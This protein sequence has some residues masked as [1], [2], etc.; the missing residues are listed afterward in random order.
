MTL[1]IQFWGAA[2]TVTGSRHLLTSNGKRVLVDAGLFQGDR[3][4]RERNWE[5]FPIPLETLDAIVLTHAHVDHIGYLP[6]L[7]A[8]GF[9][10]V[11][12]ATSATVDLAGLVLRDSAHLQEE[13]AE[14][15]N[16]KGATKHR[17]ALPLYNAQDAENALRLLQAHP[18]GSSFTP[19][20]GIDVTFERAGHIL[21]SA[22]AM[23]RTQDRVIAFSG[24]LG[25]YGQSIIPDPTPIRDCDYLVMESTYGNR[26]HPDEDPKE[27]LREVVLDVVERGGYLVAPAFAIG[28][29]QEMVYVLQELEQEG[30]IPRLPIYIDSPMAVRATPMFSR[31]REDHDLE[32]EALVSGADNPLEASNLTLTPTVDESKA[33]ARQRPPAII[34]SASGMAT[35]GRILH[36]LRRV[37]PDPKS[38]V[39]FPGFQAMGTRGRQIVDG[40]EWVSIF[41]EKVPVRARVAQLSGFSAHADRGEIMRW[42]GNF[43]Q[44]PRRTFLVHGEPEPRAALAEK[45]RRE[46]GWAVETPEHGQEFTLE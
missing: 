42:I 31:H 21:G 34:I 20:E 14:Y 25:R 44:A 26:D 5:P 17:P 39:L 15:R 24:D 2:G 43:D 16:R 37:L 41:H 12:H 33:I 4:L 35:G 27:L 8:Q 13:E 7:V 19:A 23:T 40:A 28:R 6:R 38:T 18:Y 22:F 1:H 29:T 3:E 11:V 30:A 9:G 32:M 46:R 10:G 36:H 45:I